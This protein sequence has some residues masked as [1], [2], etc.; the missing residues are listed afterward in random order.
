MECAELL[1]LLGERIRTLRKAREVSQERLAELANL[2][3]V[4]ISNVETGKVKASI[5][6]YNSIAEALGMT[7]AEL[8]E[9]P[10]EKES[11][12]S[13]MVALFQSAKRLDKD[14]QRI[15]VETVKGV[16]SGLEGL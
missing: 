9:L 8:V 13:D 11:W 5:C 2:H 12:N 4:F 14:K 7:L 16:L 10:S 6:S 15:F 3:P 1:K